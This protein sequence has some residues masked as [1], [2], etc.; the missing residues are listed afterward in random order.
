MTKTKTTKKEKFV[1]PNC[2]STNGLDVYQGL[3]KI[4]NQTKCADCGYV[5]TKE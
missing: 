4:E 5:V 1:C 2:K 3:Q